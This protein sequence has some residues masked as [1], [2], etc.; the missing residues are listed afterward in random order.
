VRGLD[1]LVVHHTAAR[2]LWIGLAATWAALELVAQ[3]LRRERRQ[4]FDWTFLVVVVSIVAG[5]NVAYRLAH[6]GD[7][8]LGGNWAPVVAGIAVVVVG[9]ALRAWAIASLG[10]FFTSQVT[11]QAGHRVI[12]S[13][14]Y[15]YL[16]HPSYTAMLVALLGLG[17]ALD[18]WP[19]ILAIV[20]LPLTGLLVRI[21]VEEHALENA[22][23]EEYRRYAAETRRLVPGVW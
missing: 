10:R 13:G 20:L 3:R 6:A 22:L 21:H 23:G 18:T 17:I 4:G 12:T 5:V 15:R 2:D 14:P 9:G 8:V 11:I 19:S 16:R 1:P 7:G